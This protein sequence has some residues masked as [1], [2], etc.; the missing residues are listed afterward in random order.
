[1]AFLKNRPGRP[2]RTTWDNPKGLLSRLV[3]VQRP[4]MVLD[5]MDKN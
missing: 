2:D 1:M 4:P 5:K 3:L